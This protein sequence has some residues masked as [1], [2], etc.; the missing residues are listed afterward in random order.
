MCVCVESPTLTTVS[1]QLKEEVL[2]AHQQLRTL[3][4][5]LRQSQRQRRNSEDSLKGST[6]SSDD[7]YTLNSVHVGLL[8]EAVLELKGLLHGFLRRGVSSGMASF[9]ESFMKM[10]SDLHKT[11]ENCEKL[12]MSLKQ[13][14]IDLKRKDDE[15]NQQLSKV[16]P[17]SSLH[18][19]TKKRFVIDQ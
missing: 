4:G 15:I 11:N 8:N 9:D 2:S 16:L 18:F 3:C 17:L 12:S 14:E 13:N 1:L 5:Q 7:D 19:I 6:S 10:E